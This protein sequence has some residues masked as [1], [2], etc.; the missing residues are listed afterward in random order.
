MPFRILTLRLLFTALSL[1]VVLPCARAQ[2]L[3]Q[4]NSLEAGW[5]AV[6]LHVDA[7]HETLDSLVGG[8]PG[9][10]ILEVWRWN[11][12]SVTQFS[13]SPATPTETIEWISWNRTNASSSL[14]RLTGDSAYLVRVAANSAPYTWTVKGRPV[15]PRA[16]WTISGLNLIGFSTVPTSP[17]N[18]QEFLAQAQEFQSATPEIYSYGGGDLD[19]SNPVLI[20]SPFLQQL[21]LVKRGQAFWVRAGTVFNRYFGP[22]EVVQRGETGVDFSDTSSSYTFRLRNLTASPLTVTLRLNASET[23]PIGQSNIVGLPP[24]LLRGAVNLTNLTYGYTNLPLN[25]P[26]AWTLAARDQEGSELQVVLGLNRTAITAPPGS[27]LAGILSFTDSLGFTL[28]Q[29]PVSAK[30][31]SSAGLWVGG[32]AVNQVGQY[33]KSY[34]RGS[35]TNYVPI[36]ST[37][38][39]YVAPSLT[40][41][42]PTVT[43]NVLLTDTNGGYIVT[44]VDTSLAAVPQAYPLRLIVHNP[45]GGDAVLLQRVYVGFD[46]DTNVVVASGESVL[47]PGY[48]S[49]ARRI[50]AT[51]LP[52]N[53]ANVAWP[54][55]GNLKQQTSLATTVTLP[56]DD[57]ASNPFLHTY[58]PDHDNLDV[59]FK[60]ALPPGSESYTVERVITLNVQPPADDFSSL[61]AGADTVTGDYLET[62]TL[63]G[64]GGDSRQFQVSGAFILNRIIPVPDLTLAP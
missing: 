56:H 6:F 23:P 1:L 47:H 27:L 50:S 8:D 28:V 60:A 61:V 53:A 45:D 14:Q 4:T 63:L 52:W 54:L 49:S 58:H 43:T 21:T 38:T 11:P 51:H 30:A 15:A 64:L 2:W 29:V 22:F 62:I 39:N 33:L 7:A 37:D 9:N 35:V 20:A 25:S 36:A 57:H 18:F 48:L 34:A 3:T 55:G 10:P 40:N 19:A 41:T 31:A 13:D 26:R 24:L 46:D 12:P 17:P 59:R 44:S 42:I 5:N 16:D 32:A